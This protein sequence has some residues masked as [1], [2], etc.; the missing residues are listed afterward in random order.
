MSKFV[1]SQESI[2]SSLL[3]WDVKSTQ[4]AIEGVYE[5]EVYPITVYDNAY[6]GPITFVIPPQIK[7]ELIDVEIIATWRVKVGDD[8]LAGE[9]VSTINNVGNS[10]WS[11]VDVQVGERLNIMQSLNQSYPYQTFFETCLN[12]DPNRADYIYAMEMFKMDDGEDKESTEALQFYHEDAVI[13][14]DDTTVLEAEKHVE[15]NAGAARA[16]RIALSHKVTTL[17]KLHSPMFRHSKALPT[18]M[19]IRVT[20]TKN[21]DGFLLIAANDSNA[22]LNIEEVFLKC[23]YIRPRDFIIK[24]QEEKLVRQPALYDVDFSELSF[25]TINIGELN[26][27]FNNVFNGK[28][29]KAAYFCIQNPVAIHGEHHRNPFTF[30]RFKSIQ[31]YKNNI[32]QFSSALV[33]EA[34]SD[35][36]TMLNQLYKSINKDLQGSCLINSKNYHLNQIIGTVFTADKTHTKHL[37]LKENGDVRVELELLKA[38]TQPLSMI[39]YAVY[40][41]IIQI[42]VNRRATII[43]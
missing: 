2:D 17:C 26:I 21:S 39:I 20:L 14:N 12:T 35:N 23:T 37:N 42:D 10:L 5:L 11:M 6:G 29:P 13:D 4:T 1:Q 22:K 31:V 3:L 15:N 18:N 9:H 43:E 28:V 25:R 8:D 16:S 33:M 27:T 7:G 36:L 24:Q 32:K 40:D 34:D 19:H 41:K 38:P 30:I